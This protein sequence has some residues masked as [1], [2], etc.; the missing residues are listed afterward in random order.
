[1][2]GMAGFIAIAG[3]LST[4]VLDKSA[5][6]LSTEVPPPPPSIGPIAREPVEAALN[7]AIRNLTVGKIAYDV[8]P[9]MRQGKQEKIEVRISR[10]ASQ[11]VA[12][13]IRER[14]RSSAQVEGIQVAPFMMVQLRDAD[15][16]TFKIVP[17]TEEKQ[18]VGGED[19][20]AWSW[21]VTPLLSGQQILYMS[22]GTRF[23]LP[24]SVEEN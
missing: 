24:N 1:M 10:S 18:A 9:E 6:N 8:P 17:L 13:T 19:Y 22:V 15:G 20:T 16:S 23:K 14:M 3:S 11:D 4:V 12:T 7:D 21:S 5:P 2:H